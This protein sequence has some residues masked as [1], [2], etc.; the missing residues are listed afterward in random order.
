MEPDAFELFFRTISKTVERKKYVR[1]VKLVFAGD[2]FDILRT[3]AWF[4][5]HKNKQP[6]D[7]TSKTEEVNQSVRS[8]LEDI[9]KVNEKSL[10]WLSGTHK[11]FKEIWKDGPEI[12]RVYI[13]G[14]HDRLINLDPSCREIVRDKLLRE[15]N[16]SSKFENAYTDLKHKTIVMHG[17]EADDLN[18]E[19]EDDGRPNYAAMPIG[20]PMTTM[21]FAQPGWLAANK[22]KYPKM[23]KEAIRRL[24]D[25]DNVRPEL[26]GL[27]YIQKIIR[28]CNV[29]KEMDEITTRLYKEFKKLPFFKDWKK[30]HS[31]WDKIKGV[32]L[33]LWGFR[34]TG[35]SIIPVA[36]TEKVA[37]FVQNRR[38][39][40][41]FEKFASKKLKSAR[42]EDI[43]FC[44]LGHT[45]EPNHVP[46]FR[47]HNG[48][49][50]H[51]LNSGT[52]RTTLSPTYDKKDFIKLQRLSFVI[53]YEPGEVRR[54]FNEPLFELWSGLRKRYYDAEGTV[55]DA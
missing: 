42:I 48:I 34:V 40:D 37:N 9:T 44:V 49:E 53:I 21:L 5:A 23:P 54:D 47:D 18:C 4:D 33:I 14:N 20:D 12:E 29:K 46:L 25:L 27:R 13:P 24:R 45:H 41:S 36:L 22:E 16:K 1:T 6:W 10:Q 19:K 3:Y 38:K 26:A 39:R 31:R 55:R 32:T 51:Y 2:I 35:S 28:N 8:I 11:D 52:F 17:H 30:A 15:K 50:K 43:R 7:S